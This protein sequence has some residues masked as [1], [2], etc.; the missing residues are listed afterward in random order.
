MTAL[1]LS[2]LVAL[3]ISKIREAF[4]DLPLPEKSPLIGAT[5]KVLRRAADNFYRSWIYLVSA[6]DLYL[7]GEAT[8]PSTGETLS[9]KDLWWRLFLIVGD[10]YDFSIRL[11]LR[12]GVTGKQ[13]VHPVPG[14]SFASA[15]HWLG[16]VRIEDP[17]AVE[18]E[19]ALLAGGDLLADEAERL[20]TSPLSPFGVSSLEEAGEEIL[21]DRH[22]S[23]AALFA[24]SYL[25]AQTAAMFGELL[26]WAN[27]PSELVEKVDGIAHR[28]AAVLFGGSYSSD[29]GW[30]PQIQ[31]LVQRA[32]ATI[33]EQWVRIYG[34]PD[35]DESYSH[36]IG[37]FSSIR[38]SELAPLAVRDSR[39]TKKYGSK[40]IEKVFE[41]QLALIVQ[42]FGLYVVSTRMGQ[43]TVDLVCISADPTAHLTFLI[44]AKTSRRPYA[45]PRDDARA[46][47]EYI[48]DVRNGL[49]TLPP[50]HF[51]LMLGPSP[52]ATLEKKL[53]GLEAEAGLPI[54][55][56]SAQE[57][58]QLREVVTG[59]LPLN[60]FADHLL[61]ASRVVPAGFAQTMRSRVD[62]L[63]NSHEALV[64]TMLAPSVSLPPAP[65]RP[66]PTK[67]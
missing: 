28:T 42:S 43:R 18:R 50:L 5:P 35:A 67:R 56:C 54:R 4:L 14:L 62:E 44:E 3:D 59:P 20:R 53:Q 12:A 16:K 51:V 22:R 19:P 25:M 57:F 39:M 7:Q 15:E 11:L 10:Y 63:R 1:E 47:L 48:R 8:V 32:V 13:T 6:K 38:L 65:S 49:T 64:R 60:D 34:K 30:P 27:V 52:S 58:A 24:G 46:L 9:G 31:E 41:Q 2:R 66:L 17:E 40:R 26:R 29:E 21:W 33:F 61:L 23:L 45:L 37:P 55:Y 36:R